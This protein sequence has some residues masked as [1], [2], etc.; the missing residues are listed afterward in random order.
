MESIQKDICS[1]FIDF[2]GEDFVDVQEPA[3]T[4]TIKIIIYFPKL[5]VTNEGNDSIDIK[6]TYVRFSIYD[7]G[8]ISTHINVARAYYTYK[9]YASHYVHSHCPRFNTP[10]QWSAFCLGTG[11]ITFTMFN[12]CRNITNGNVDLD[13]YTLFASE[14]KLLLGVESLDGGPYIT[15]SSVHNYTEYPEELQIQYN[16]KMRDSLMDGFIDYLCRIQ[17]FE[18]NFNGYYYGFA[19]ST[20]DLMIL[21][22]NEFIK[23]CNTFSEDKRP[24]MDTLFSLGVLC[25]GFKRSGRI[26]KYT[27]GTLS[28]NNIPKATAITFKGKVVPLIVE[29]D[30]SNKKSY[31]VLLNPSKFAYVTTT[32]LERLNYA[33]TSGNHPESPSITILNCG[34]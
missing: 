22:A 25:K 34:Q 7:D 30:K 8:S 1:R 23:Y 13:L 14:L 18:F 33:A 20:S 31:I 26:Y 9:Q 12:I 19:Y 21:M 32:I 4:S 29:P 6:D 2:F 16:I 10:G 27:N 5:T 28:V 3:N 11:P 24:N 15:L 17:P